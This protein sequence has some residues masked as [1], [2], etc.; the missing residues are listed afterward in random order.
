MPLLFFVSPVIYQ[1]RDL[2]AAA[3][4]MEFNPLA[5]WIRIVRDP[6]LGTVPAAV[7]Y[8]VA[9]A[10]S[11]VGWAFALWVTGARGHRLPY[12]V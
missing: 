6:L 2:G 5:H 9:I 7:T 4:V 1:A 10:L 3:I 8:L 11:V 12:W